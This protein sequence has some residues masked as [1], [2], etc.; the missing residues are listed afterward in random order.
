LVVRGALSSAEVEGLAAA[1]DHLDTHAEEYWDERGQERNLLAVDPDNF[2]P[3]LTHPVTLPLVAQLMGPRLQLHTSQFLWRHPDTVEPD[4]PG[5][6]A[7][8]LGWVSC[9]L[10][11]TKALAR[12]ACGQHVL[13]RA[14]SS[15]LVSFCLAADMTP[16]HRCLCMQHR[17]IAEMTS[18]IGPGVMPRVEIKVMFYLSDCD[19]PGYGQTWVAAGSHK[20]HPGDG[21][22]YHGPEARA[23]IVDEGRA[24]EPL[25]KVCSGLLCCLPVPGLLLHA[26]PSGHSR[27]WHL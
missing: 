15:R 4:S 2:L 8:R 16:A 25:L 24:V 26:P 10:L 23:R 12:A 1:G 7:T 22:P 20:W 19:K 5:I 21:G 27:I 13:A 14:R 3:L 9:G 17:D 18:V 11:M 6:D